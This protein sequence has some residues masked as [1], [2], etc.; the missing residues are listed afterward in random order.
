MEIY[1]FTDEEEAHVFASTCDRINEI[2]QYCY[3]EYDQGGWPDFVNRPDEV[4][5][6]TIKSVY[7]CVE[8]GFF[9]RVGRWVGQYI[10][11]DTSIYE[12]EWCSTVSAT[13]LSTLWDTIDE[14]IPRLQAQP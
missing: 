4:Y 13:L 8:T 11:E 10:V 7:D 9:F 3:D 1:R 2:D 5:S 14:T 6:Y 12:T